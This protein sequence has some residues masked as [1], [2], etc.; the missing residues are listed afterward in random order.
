VY[1]RVKE[2]E[3]SATLFDMF[4]KF[5]RLA[6]FGNIPDIQSTGATIPVSAEIV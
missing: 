4:D 5:A 3:Y 6:G 2:K 1:G